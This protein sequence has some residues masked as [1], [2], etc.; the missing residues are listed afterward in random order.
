VHAELA[1]GPKTKK[2]LARIFGKTDGAISS[3]GLRLRNEG[4]ITRIWRGGRFMWARVSPTAPK[5]IPAP[6]AIVKA[7]KK[8]PMNVPV[9]AQATGKGTSTVKCALR[10]HLLRNGTVIR[11]GF[12]VYALPGARPPYVSRGQAIV[13]ALKNGRMSF[14][15][16]AREINNPPSSLP[17][18]LEPL[19]A[20]G[21]VIRAERGI[22]ALPGSAP[23]YVPTCDAIIHALAKKPM[24]LGALIRHVD[25]STKSTRSRGTICTV[26]SR[27]TKQGTV[28][29]SRRGSEYRLARRVLAERGRERTA[30]GGRGP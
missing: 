30:R 18:F 6:D 12:G 15:A 29:Q 8:G 20:K 5:F 2:E 19:L 1:D 21:T 27:L 3:V 25:K 28:K 24:K 16:L 26:L 17:Q 11:T 14:Q 10:R 23:V 22:Y 7:L 13:E 4:K 9:L